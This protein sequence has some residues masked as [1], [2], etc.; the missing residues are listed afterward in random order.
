MSDAVRVMHYKVIWDARVVGGAV[1]LRMNG[2]AQNEFT[3]RAAATVGAPV[4]TLRSETYFIDGPSIAR[5]YPCDWLPVRC[6]EG[7]SQSTFCL[8]DRPTTE[9]LPA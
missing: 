4:A 5:R 9:E 8:P 1:V 7:R 3:V 6:M 2:S